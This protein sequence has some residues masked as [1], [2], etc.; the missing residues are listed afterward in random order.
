M[1]VAHPSLV[2]FEGADGGTGEVTVDGVIMGVRRT[3][4][5]RGDLMGGKL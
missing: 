5:G 4:T 3:F 1:D 2:L